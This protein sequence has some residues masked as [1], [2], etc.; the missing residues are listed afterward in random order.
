MK[1]FIDAFEYLN[2]IRHIDLYNNRELF[3]KSDSNK[4]RITLYFYSKFSLYNVINLSSLKEPTAVI[5]SS[6]KII[7]FFVLFSTSS[8]CP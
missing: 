4:T 2:L 5:E 1:Y 7:I 3:G 6:I 8:T